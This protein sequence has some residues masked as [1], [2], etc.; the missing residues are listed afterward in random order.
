MAHR[1]EALYKLTYD[2]FNHIFVS[3][4]SLIDL[5]SFIA[6]EVL[7]GHI[8]GNVSECKIDGTSPRV[9]FKD[10]ALYKRILYNLKYERDPEQT[11]VLGVPC[12]VWKIKDGAGKNTFA[13]RF[14]VP[15]WEECT[16]TGL[17]ETKRV[18]SARLDPA[19]RNALGLD[20]PKI[21]RLNIVRNGYAEVEATT[22]EEAI[23]KG[24]MLT[25]SDFD[26]EDVDQS[27]LDEI[28]I[29]EE[30]APVD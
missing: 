14:T 24:K 12:K 23:E 30:F 8:I 27:V 26:W 28:T 10:D 29:V 17:R 5:F 3:A 13:Y 18:I 6:N 19:V 21:Y 20:K 16:T 22:D 9:R 11:E 2:G 15:G 1:I 4:T 25:K 7:A